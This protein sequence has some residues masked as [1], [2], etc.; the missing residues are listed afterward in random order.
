MNKSGDLNR[1]VSRTKALIKDSFL[2]LAQDKQFSKISVNEITKKANISRSTFYLHYCDTYDLIDQIEN[3]TIQKIS[4]AFA[5]INRNQY[6]PGQHPQHTAVIRVLSENR[7]IC[8][9]LLGKNGDSSFY[10]K[11]IDALTNNFFMNW[12]TAG[13]NRASIDGI[14]LYVRY[15]VCGI[16]G[17][18]MQTFEAGNQ[19]ITEEGIHKLGYFTGEVTN[20]IDEQFVLPYCTPSKD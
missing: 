1:S 3:E 15:V 7:E 5:K 14:H 20:W 4:D 10:Q 9:F 11:L 13:G 17:V 2:A 19:P 8:A 16:L 12:S 18:F 6:I